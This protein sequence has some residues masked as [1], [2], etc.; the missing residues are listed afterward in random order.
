MTVVSG[1]AA[2]LLVQPLLVRRL[3]RV[4][5]KGHRVDRTLQHAR[6][7]DHMILLI[8]LTTIPATGITP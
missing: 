5:Q 8:N 6:G 2:T 4:F 7:A 3:N 1:G